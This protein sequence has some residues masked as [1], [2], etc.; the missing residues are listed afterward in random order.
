MEI[1]STPAPVRLSSCALALSVLWYTARRVVSHVSYTQSSSLHASV[2]VTSARYGCDTA[3]ATVPLSL[4]A[5]ADGSVTIVGNSALYRAFQALCT[6]KDTSHRPHSHQ[7]RNLPRWYRVVSLS[8]SPSLSVTVTVSEEGEHQRTGR[9]W[10]CRTIRSY[11][12]NQGDEP[13]T[14]AGIGRRTWRE[15][16]STIT[17]LTVATTA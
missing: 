6:V 3:P 2:S 4:E 9:R 8:P 5:S 14:A 12:L 17:Q 10:W 16:P 11:R 13:V 15:G 7:N 1:R